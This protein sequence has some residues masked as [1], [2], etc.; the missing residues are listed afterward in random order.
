[1]LT[2]TER[3]ANLQQPEAIQDVLLGHYA[4]MLAAGALFLD[5]TGCCKRLSLARGAD[6]RAE[7]PTD[8]VRAALAPHVEVVRRSRRA[9]LAPQTPALQDAHVLLAALPV[10]NAEIGVVIVLRHG[11]CR[12]FVPSDLLAAEAVLAYGA[13]LMSNAAMVRNLQRSAL[14]TVCALVNAIDAKDNY[15][16]DHSERVGALARLTGQA[17][18]LSK[19]QLQSLEWAGFLHDVGKI[20]IAESILNKPGRLTAT[21]FQQVMNHP[22]IGHDMLRP[23]GRFEPVLETV[24]YHHENHDGSGYPNGLSGTRIP[25]EARIV[26]VVDIFDALTSTRPYRAAYSLKHALFLLRHHAG[27]VTD[28]HVTECF[29]DAL[30]RQVADDPDGFR[31]RFSH[32]TPGLITN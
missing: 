17:L 6:E 23:V 32:L 5:A 27:R 25:L 31:T 9:V 22:R 30:Q 1:M 19:E 7:L 28:P 26:H 12:S 13:Q 20:G 2:L 10:A 14:E 11:A 4:E 29:I 24:L 8:Q 3:I 16:S 15:T 18:T 21:E